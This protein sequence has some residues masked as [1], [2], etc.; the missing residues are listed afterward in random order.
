MEMR[1]GYL[2]A[3]SR[4]LVEYKYSVW[5]TCAVSPFLSCSLV[6]LPTRSFI[7]VSLFDPI[8]CQPVKKL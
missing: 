5:R 6:H 8:G 2:K 4:V 1:R 3:E 7:G